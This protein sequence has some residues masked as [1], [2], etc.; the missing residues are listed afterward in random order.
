MEDHHVFA[1]VK[2]KLQANITQELEKEQERN[3]VSRFV[4][5][6]NQAYDRLKDTV[7]KTLC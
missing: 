4:D 3:R 2:S 6:T 1:K 7:F 5:P